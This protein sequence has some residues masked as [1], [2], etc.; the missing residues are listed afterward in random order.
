MLAAAVLAFATTSARAQTLNT[1]WW[2][3]NGRVLSMVPSQDGSVIYM[4]G[5]FTYAGPEAMCGAVLQFDPAEPVVSAP[6]P[7]GTVYCSVSDGAGGWFIGGDF[8][9][10]G[11]QD[12]TRLAHLNADGSVSSWQVDVAG[13]YVLSMT[14]DG[15]TLYF[16]GNFTSVGGQTRYGIA[17]VD[18]LSGAALP[19]APEVAIS[20]SLYV[21]SL[22]VV[23]Q[24]LLLGGSF[25]TV[26]G[27]T[28]P[29]LA[30][31]DKVDGSTNAWAPTPSDDVLCLV[32]SQEEN[33]VY[34]GGNFTTM[35]GQPRQRTAA[36][37]A[38]TYALL[39]WTVSATDPVW[40][41]AIDGAVMVLGGRFEQLAGQPREYLGAVD[42]GSGAVLPW[43]ADATWYVRSLAINDGVVYVGGEFR[44]LD[45]PVRR[46][47]G[48]VDLAT[49]E[50]TDWDP[51]ASEDVYTLAVSGDRLFAGGVFLSIGG[52]VRNKILAMDR[53]TG[54]PT[55]W[56]AQ[57]SDFG[58]ISSLC[59]SPDG[60]V[61]YGS[62]SF[63]NA[64][65]GT[66]TRR[67]M[68]ALDASTGQALPW[69]PQPNTAPWEMVL[70]PD[71]ST[72]YVS[73][74]FTTIGGL[75]RN[76][77]AA[78]N[79]DPQQ[80]QVTSWDPNCTGGTV[81]GIAIAPDGGTLYAAGFFDAGDGTIGGQPRDH[82]A[83]LDTGIDTDNATSW[84]APIT[85]GNNPYARTIVLDPTGSTLYVGG[86]FNAAEGHTVSGQARDNL[87]AVSTT[88]GEALP[89]NPGAND[90]VFELKW[91]ADGELMVCGSFQGPGAIG[92]QERMTFAYVDPITGAVG[93]F[94]ATFSGATGVLEA[95]DLGDLLIVGGGFFFVN[96]TL[97]EGLAVF[98]T[99]TSIPENE[100]AGWLRAFPVPTNS[101]LWLPVV[102]DAR[103]VEVHDATGR[104]VRS[105]AYA[106]AV[107][108]HD[109][110]AGLYILRLRGTA[111]RELGRCRVVVEH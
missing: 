33:T 6:M 80:T 44:E 5:M 30:A 76:R 13:G 37:D 88:T 39:P 68:V 45:G 28:R 42:L 89:W 63:N 66:A 73:G 2:Q 29:F 16:G 12:R 97:R 65:F 56:D 72:I 69:A 8:D 25:D 34:A 53:A 15:S 54:R 64:T 101:E 70:S 46:H 43:V 93:P 47:I 86:S 32:Y 26:N 90:D 57:S 75:P 83:A 41:M 7:N 81:T 49:A 21:S 50:V 85:G 31:V 14:L 20:G 92:G 104:L 78:I 40:T 48:A 108:L 109:L 107:H 96:G 111:G 61:L 9:A 67:H 4:G 100:D 58:S 10:A 38:S 19:F 79:A 94:S 99:P 87:A 59:M 24:N 35:G 102:A 110:T 98:D 62:G 82:L 1:D 55:D 23:G 18:A 60:Q 74:D 27:L 106:R 95:E 77:L 84:V 52:V 103:T 51:V 22:L 17:A 36:F 3:V 71:G 11:D 91:S 105:F